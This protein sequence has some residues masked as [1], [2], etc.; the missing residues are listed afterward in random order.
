[1]K[2][3]QS[4]GAGSN[5]KS[6]GQGASVEKGSDPMPRGRGHIPTSPMKM[7]IKDFSRTKSTACGTEKSY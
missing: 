4:K 6:F 2:G 3:G 1:M 7:E 5:I